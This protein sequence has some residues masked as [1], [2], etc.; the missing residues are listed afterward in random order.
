[1]WFVKLGQGTDSKGTIRSALELLEK[2]VVYLKSVR[3][4]KLRTEVK[5]RS[6]ELFFF[7]NLRC[8]FETYRFMILVLGKRSLKTR[9]G[10]MSNC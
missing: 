7:F 3:T 1:M 6:L 8:T 4:Y 9:K 5:L 2:S 10:E